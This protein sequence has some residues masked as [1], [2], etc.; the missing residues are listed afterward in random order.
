MD[1]VRFLASGPGR[2]VRAGVGGGLIA[3]GIRAGGGWRVVAVLGAVPLAA[4]VFDFCLLGPV[5]RLPIGGPGLRA[6][7]GR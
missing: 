3:A 6:R 7:V 1:V 4:G 2:L 5:L